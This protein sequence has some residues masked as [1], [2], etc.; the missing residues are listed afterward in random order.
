MAMAEKVRH[1]RGHYHTSLT[2][3]TDISISKT[4]NQQDRRYLYQT[5]DLSSLCVRKKDSDADQLVDTTDNNSKSE[6]Q[7]QDCDDIRGKKLDMDVLLNAESLGTLVSH[8]L[9]II[10]R[11][12]KLLDDNCSDMCHQAM[13]DTTKDES[14]QTLCLSHHSC[15]MDVESCDTTEDRHADNSSSVLMKSLCDLDRCDVCEKLHSKLG[16]YTCIW[17]PIYNE[18]C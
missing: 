2:S 13:T 7:Q 15:E 10:A 4:I 8:K 11:S 6:N 5:Q 9:D 1:R 12:L 16:K 18:L 17:G 3:L 14:L